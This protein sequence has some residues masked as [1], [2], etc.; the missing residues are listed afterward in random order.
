MRLL[1]ELSNL[2][3]NIAV[4]QETHFT[5]TADC[6]VLEKDFVAFSSYGCCSSA[7]VSLL[8]GCSLDADVN[9]VFAGDEGRLVVGDVAVKSLKFRV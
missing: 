3:G 4:V 1:A 6:Q 9:V 5:C 7:E 8:V 2:S